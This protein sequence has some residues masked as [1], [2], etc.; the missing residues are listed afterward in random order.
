MAPFPPGPPGG[1][2]D[3]R[4]GAIIRPGRGAIGPAQAEGRRS[5]L[6]AIKSAPASPRLQVRVRPEPRRA[7]PPEQYAPAR[8]PVL[9]AL[10]AGHAVFPR[11]RTTNSTRNA[12]DHATI[13]GPMRDSKPATTR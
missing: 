11:I 5:P 1:N 13:M 8:E 9:P 6:H 4:A 7:G 10:A 12:V 3:A 2:R